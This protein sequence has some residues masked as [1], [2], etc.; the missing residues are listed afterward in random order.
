MNKQEA[1]FYFQNLT[2]KFKPNPNNSLVHH[3]QHFP[4]FNKK[5]FL[6]Q[7][8]GLF[9]NDFLF[10]VSYVGHLAGAG[11]GLLLGILVLR[12]L[13]EETWEKYLWWLCL[14]V[15]SLLVLVGVIWNS[16]II[17]GAWNYRLI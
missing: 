6:F 12:N 8:Q 14:A 16:V 7:N 15:F 17:F 5:K 11:A 10:Q 2:W 9:T 4:V 1:V 13:K 3:S